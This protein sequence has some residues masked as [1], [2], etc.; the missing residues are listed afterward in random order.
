MVIA[1]GFSASYL[2]VMT[3]KQSGLGILE[4]VAIAG[5][6]LGLVGMSIAL[7]FRSLAAVSAAAMSLTVLLTL[8]WRVW[9]TTFAK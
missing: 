7:H 1:A 2:L 8:Q 5:C 9:R 3:R 6:W 4:I